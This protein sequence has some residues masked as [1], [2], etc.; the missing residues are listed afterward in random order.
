MIYKG[1]H[2]D[3]ILHNGMYSARLWLDDNNGSEYLQEFKADTLEGI[4]N[5]IDTTPHNV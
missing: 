1:I 5:I 2:I 4:Q 3:R